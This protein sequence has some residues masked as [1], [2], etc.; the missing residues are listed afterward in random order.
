MRYLI[1]GASTTHGYNDIKHGGW[2]GRLR[3]Y[4]NPKEF[5]NLAISGNTSFDILARIESETVSRLRDKPKEEWTM[6]LG[7]GTNDARIKNGKPGS[8]PEQYKENVEKLL[9][10]AQKYVG[11]VLFLSGKPV[12]EELTTP[13]DSRS[14]FYNEDIKRNGGIAKAICDARGVE[15]IDLYSEFEK[16]DNLQELLDDGLHPNAKGHEFMFNIIHKYI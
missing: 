3:Q 14:S 4:L 8:T 1:F 10:I 2:A 15:F 16:V 13:F 6:I 7:L 5:H 12:I 9:D 11:R